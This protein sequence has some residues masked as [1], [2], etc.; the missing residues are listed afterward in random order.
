MIKLSWRVIEL[1]RKDSF[2]DMKIK[3]LSYIFAILILSAVL[4]VGFIVC[5]FATDNADEGLD[6]YV[7]K[8]TRSDG[9][10]EYS[11]TF[12]GAFSDISDGDY[13]EFLPET[14]DVYLA[15]YAKLYSKSK[16]NVTID[17]RGSTIIAPE[18]GDVNGQIFNIGDQYGSRYT[19]LMENAKIYAA[20]GGRCAFSVFNTSVIEIDGGE[21]GGIIYA[22]GA[23]NLTSKYSDPETC[24]V[25]KNIYAFKP[26]V[27]MAGMICARETSQL[28]LID[29]YAVSTA[30]SGV[31]LYV[32]NSGRMI[33]ENSHG[34]SLDGGVVLQF[35][36]ATD[37]I[38]FT[39]GAGSTLYGNVKDLANDSRMS[40]LIGAL[41]QD[42][43]STNIQEGAVMESVSKTVTHGI[44]TSTAVGSDDFE[45]ITFE[46]FYE[47][48]RDIILEDTLTDTEQSDSVWEL[49]DVD[50]NKKYSNHIY[51]PF[52]DLSKFVNYTLLSDVVFEKTLKLNLSGDIKIDINQK[53]ISVVDN[54]SSNAFLFE[55]FGDGVLTFSFADS[56]IDLPSASLILADSIKE[57]KMLGAGGFIAAKN[58]VR[59]KSVPLSLNGGYYSVT[60]NAFTVDNSTINATAITVYAPSGD[61]LLDSDGDVTMNTGVTLISPIGAYAVRCGAKLMVADGINIFGKIFV[62]E[63]YSAGNVGFSYKPELEF[64][65]MLIASE[66]S[67]LTLEIKSLV[68]GK[69]TTA[70][71][72]FTVTY[73]T[74][75]I[76][77]GLK[78]SMTLSSFATLN[79]YVPESV[80][81]SNNDFAVRIV[82]SGLLYEAAAK[83]GSSVKVNGKS[84]VKFS[85]PYVYP[86]AYS[87]SA[88]ITLTSGGFVGDE[89]LL[90]SDYFDAAFSATDDEALKS[91]IA[92][93]ARYSAEC[94]GVKLSEESALMPYVK[95]ITVYEEKESEL[96]FD[97]FRSIR[98][99]PFENE[100]RFTPW[101]SCDYTLDISYTYGDKLLSYSFDSKEG[102]FAVPVF[103]F[104][105]TSDFIMVFTDSESENTLSINLYELANF[106]EEGTDT[107]M[108]LTMYLSYANSLYDYNARV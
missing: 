104:D 38:K 31:S 30:K 16:V 92:S 65:N 53:K 48:V 78:A 18:S 71:S 49:E 32:R 2:T 35:V 99:E 105:M 100:L 106:A 34:I 5:S 72:R 81:K 86:S 93:Y 50:G 57:V 20:H 80:V 60:Q 59:T 29:C 24:S 4:S 62:N 73:K 87:E 85:Y 89:E 7:W 12:N 84:Y 21:A 41:I 14:Y 27:N 96:L 25:M 10:V 44:Y 46:Y 82:L 70:M 90:I 83:D 76:T 91:V 88:K 28:K 47:V 103:K 11:S 98:Y 39:L 69:I 33:L 94:S 101:T 45:E 97:Y 1:F 95:N 64:S 54:F 15:D 51:L 52:E 43:Y 13:Y 17:L 107:R 40:I 56:I 67:N 3:R 63:F 42:A 19:V 36:E 23:L 108:L 75:D 58:A 74:V 6:S 66:R 102:P 77:S 8:I 22:G 55:A 61:V 79:V 26:T 9:S 37:K 68:N